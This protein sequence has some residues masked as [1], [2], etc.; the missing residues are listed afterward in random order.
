VSDVEF[1]APS[2]PFSAQLS[3]PGDKSMSHR[4]LVLAAMAHGRSSIAGLGPGDDV[5]ATAAALARLG[6]TVGPD[7]VDS[8]GILGWTAPNEPLDA[9]NSGTTIRLLTGAL[10]GRPFPT[11]LVGDDSLM[12]RPMSRLVAPLGALGASIEVA[13]AGTAPVVV[14]GGSL[15]GA[16]VVLPIP[17]AQ[18]RTAVALAALQAE[19]PTTV[20][21]PP[22]FRD[23]TE[24]WLASLGLGRW[25]TSTAFHIE[26]G[27]VPPLSLSLPGDPSSAAFLAAA[28]ALTSGSDVLLRGI[29]LNPGR[30]GFF[31]VLEMMGA[32]VVRSVTGAVHG[33]PVGDVTVRAASL[34]GVRIRAP[35]TVRALDEVPLI[36]VLAGVATGETEVRDAAELTAKESDRVAAT[37]A[38]IRALG[39]SAEARADGLTVAGLGTRYPGGTVEAGGDH[40]IAMAAAVAAAACEESVTIRGFE[41]VNVSWPGFRSTL[42]DVWS[43]SP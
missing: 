4:A 32:V 40:R 5:E 43:S 20:D 11:T 18:V 30:T 21:S 16:N 37:V 19:G 26:P 36:A 22:G 3:L 42:E 9:R 13:P 23:H 14:H 17:S 38:M 35:L 41:A 15:R 25:T 39:G 29:S 28:A 12:R 1:T 10:C 7:G 6:V 2:R 34:R 8:P 31:D 24:R 33:D 27:P